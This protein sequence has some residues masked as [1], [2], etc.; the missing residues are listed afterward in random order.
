MA[1]ASDAVV[2]DDD[3]NERP[4]E[5]HPLVE[6]TGI[7]KP[8][9]QVIDLTA[10]DCNEAACVAV[11]AVVDLSDDDSDDDESIFE[12]R[13]VAS[14]IIPDDDDDVMKQE[15]LSPRHLTSFTYASHPP[16]DGRCPT[17]VVL[18]RHWPWS[19]SDVCR[20]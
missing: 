14:M 5:T 8:P 16:R 13:A 2:G 20:R 4:K 10:D 3:G 12:P 7:A 15:D 11:T 6:F 9:V 19:I 17:T 1:T 18:G